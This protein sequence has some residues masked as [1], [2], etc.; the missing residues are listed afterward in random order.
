LHATSTMGNRL[1]LASLCFCE[2][3]WTCFPWRIARLLSP[4]QARAKCAYNSRQMQSVPHM[5]VSATMQCVVRHVPKLLD[6]SCL[7]QLDASTFLHPSCCTRFRVQPVA[8]SLQWKR[9]TVITSTVQTTKQ[10]AESQQC[11]LVARSSNRVKAALP[12][13]S[14]WSKIKRCGHSSRQSG[15][16]PWPLR[17]ALMGSQ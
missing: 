9:S 2:L 7:S 4:L 14:G 11:V 6:I 17:P 8:E 10:F 5:V 12:L 13:V 1:S 3:L 16:E 15:R